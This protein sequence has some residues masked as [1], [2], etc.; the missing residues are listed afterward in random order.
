MCKKNALEKSTDKKR[1][2]ASSR[3]DENEKYGENYTNKYILQT[4]RNEIIIIKSAHKHELKYN[5]E[6][7]LLI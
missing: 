7:N 5:R 3:E 4:Q 2:A 1:N 6:Y